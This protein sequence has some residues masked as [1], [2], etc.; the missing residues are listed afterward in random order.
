MS[1]E[2]HQDH[3]A[4][5]HAHSGE[6]V[7]HWTRS[8]NMESIERFGLHP[9]ARP[10]ERGEGWSRA[11][12]LYFSTQCGSFEKT[13]LSESAPNRYMRVRVDA[14]DLERIEPDD[15]AISHLGF[16][17][18]F[19]DEADEI[20]DSWGYTEQSEWVMGKAMDMDVHDNVACALDSQAFAYRGDVPAHLIEVRT[21]DGWQPLAPRPKLDELGR[22]PKLTHEDLRDLHG[23]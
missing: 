14:L 3:I 10:T 13:D 22:A 6:Y 7:Y 23:W 17:E 18:E 20:H 9:A 16:N 8:V 12:V 19:G 11:G 2:A 1:D 4:T 21:A 15:D 5:W